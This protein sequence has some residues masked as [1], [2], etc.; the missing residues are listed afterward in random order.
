VTH[1]E[2][3]REAIPLAFESSDRCIFV[4]ACGKACLG[5]PKVGGPSIGG[6]KPRT[7]GNFCQNCHTLTP[8]AR[9]FGALLALAPL[10][11]ESPAREH[12]LQSF[13]HQRIARELGKRLPQVAFRTSVVGQCKFPKFCR[14]QEPSCAIEGRPPA[15]SER[16]QLLFP[17]SRV[18]LHPQQLGERRRMIRVFM[19]GGVQGGDRLFPGPKLAPT[20]PREVKVGP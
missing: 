1:E 12:P 13:E 19:E 11:A 20:E 16:A 6:R 15:R 2:A 7:L 9:R 17:T 3:R 18:V 8:S 4:D 14:F 5:E 10:I